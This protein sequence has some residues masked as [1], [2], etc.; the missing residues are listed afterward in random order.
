MEDYSKLDNLFEEKLE[1]LFKDI[2]SIMNSLGFNEEEIKIILNTNKNLEEILLIDL[3][4]D[5]H[6][7]LIED[8]SQTA[9][10]LKNK[11]LMILKYY[12]KEKKNNSNFNKAMEKTI[13]EFNDALARKHRIGK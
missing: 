13:E 12:L 10:I 4:H 11:L 3:F 9:N 8:T 5:A 6:D 1:L 7:R 2:N